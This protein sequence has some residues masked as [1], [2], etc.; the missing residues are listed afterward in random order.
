MNGEFKNIKPIEGWCPV[1]GSDQPEPWLTSWPRRN[2]CEYPV[3]CD[4]TVKIIDAWVKPN[5]KKSK[6]HSG[7]WIYFN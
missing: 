2:G 6:R 3:S 1:Y 5:K 7:P 4:A